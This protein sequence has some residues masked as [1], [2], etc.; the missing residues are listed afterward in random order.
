MRKVS[1]YLDKYFHQENT[2]EKTGKKGVHG[3]WSYPNPEIIQ[4]KTKYILGQT[5]YVPI[6][7]INLFC[8]NQ[9]INIQVIMYGE[10]QPTYSYLQTY[11]HIPR[12]KPDKNGYYRKSTDDEVIKYVKMF[13]SKIDK[14]LHL[15]RE[16]K[17]KRILGENN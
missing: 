12:G 6:H 13:K 10:F 17:L 4:Y 7:K 16:E 14:E 15:D 5:L 9:T 1:T 3:S 11:D 2:T 8:N